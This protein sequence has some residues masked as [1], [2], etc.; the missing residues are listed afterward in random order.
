[1]RALS[2]LLE[3]RIESE[4][5]MT[6]VISQGGA[7]PSKFRAL[8]AARKHQKPLDQEAGPCTPNRL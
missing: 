8:E 1:M 2:W 6:I 5:V 7:D 4:L 3:M